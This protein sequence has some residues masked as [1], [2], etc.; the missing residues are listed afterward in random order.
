LFNDL[1]DVRPDSVT[2]T[3]DTTPLRDLCSIGLGPSNLSLAALATPIADL[4][5]V[6]LEANDK[7]QWHPGLMLPQAELQVS[8]LKDL[9]TLVDPTNP[10]SFLNFL[11]DQ[12]RL[13]RF[14]IANR[15]SNV[16]RAEFS[17]YYSWVARTIPSIRFGHRVTSVDHDGRSFIVWSA[18]KPP[19]RAR[20]LVVGV[21]HDPF[22]PEV[23]R[24]ALGDNLFH[25]SEFLQRDPKLAGRTVVIIGGGQTGAE[26]V[27]H[28]LGQEVL[29]RRLT[30]VSRRHGFLP[31]DDSAFSNEWFNPEFVRRFYKLPEPTRRSLLASQQLASNGISEH[32][33]GRI[34]RRLYEL[35]YLTPD[36][37]RYVLRPSCELAGVTRDGDLL[38]VVVDD[39]ISGRRDT[40]LAEVVIL[41][42]G[43]RHVLPEVIRPLLGDSGF[44]D[45]ETTIDYSL[46]WSGDAAG[47]IYLQN[48]AERTHGI[49]DPNLSLAAWRSAVIINS[50]L[51][52]DAY[53]TGINGSVLWRWAESPQAPELVSTD[54]RGL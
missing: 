13:Y 43:Y 9:V 6:F 47:R 25:A 18:G 40:L 46:R 53:R 34:Y 49:A 11:A 3:L 26:L 42:T 48:G 37:L 16:S 15:D 45:V 23:A 17:Q 52:R 35:D 51:G 44:G 8:Y 20:N 29:P 19:V 21:G 33:L 14:L 50:V 4:T 12:G 30:W 2:D 28:I 24:P 39:T 10:Y 7:F 5:S 32:L 31:L 36:R 22:V 41:A 1:D 38:Q 27:D 54:R